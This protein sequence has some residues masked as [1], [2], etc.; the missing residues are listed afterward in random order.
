LAESFVSG[1]CDVFEK[2]IKFSFGLRSFGGYADGR[3]SGDNKL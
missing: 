3:I 1:G 2:Y